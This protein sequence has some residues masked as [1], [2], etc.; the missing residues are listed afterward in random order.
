MLRRTCS[1]L[2]LFESPRPRREPS[3]AALSQNIWHSTLFHLQTPNGVQ[4]CQ[5]HDADVREDRHPHVG[6]SQRA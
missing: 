4:Y 2:M 6:Q 5:H 3:P 1:P